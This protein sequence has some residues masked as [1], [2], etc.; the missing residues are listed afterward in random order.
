[1]R[2]PT[3]SVRSVPSASIRIS[4][5][6][7]RR[8]TSA[9]LAALSSRQA[10]TGSG[11]SRNSAPVDEGGVLVVGHPGL[12]GQRR[13]RPER[14]AP[15]PRQRAPRGPARRARRGAGDQRRVDAGQRARC[16]PARRSARRRRSPRARPARAG[17]KPSSWRVAGRG[18]RSPRPAPAGRR[19]SSGQAPRSQ[20]RAVQRDA[21]APRP[22]VVEPTSTCWP[23][24]DLQ[25]PVAEQRR[26]RVGVRAGHGASSSGK[27]SARCARSDSQHEPPLG[28]R[29][30]P[31]AAEQ[32]LLAG[33]SHAGDRPRHGEALEQ[34]LDRAL[35]GV[36]AVAGRRRASSA[37]SRR[38]AGVSAPRSS[39][40][41]ALGVGVLAGRATAEL[42]GCWR[43]RRPTPWR[44]ARAVRRGRLLELRRRRRR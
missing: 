33:V 41:V 40:H 34:Q 12:L 4:R 11:R 44:A 25:A 19:R 18:G 14:P 20:D 9:R 1:M 31:V 7:R 32:L 5:A 24:C 3:S 26:E 30:H 22:S 17:A 37:Y 16:W 36:L 38:V 29:G 42:L 35:P 39:Q 10:A 8:S 23:G 15:A 27:C 28:G 43:W 13:R 2:P 6:S 21:P